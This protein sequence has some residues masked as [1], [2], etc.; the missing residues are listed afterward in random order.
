MPRRARGGIR[1]RHTPCGLHST[2]PLRCVPRSVT[3]L[4]ERLKVLRRVVRPVLVRMVHMQLHGRTA[5]LA[6]RS[7][8]LPSAH[9]RARPR[10]STLA[11]RVGAGKRAE[12]ALREGST[13]LHP[14]SL[15][16][17]PLKGRATSLADLVR[18]RQNVGPPSH[19]LLPR[20]LQRLRG[21]LVPRNRQT[22]QPSAVRGAQ[23][24]ATFHPGR[25]A[26]QHL[27]RGR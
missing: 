21:A 15:Q 4:A 1:G 20:T 13:V 3:A 22:H 16:A 6:A 18:R 23:L 5:V 8:K 2:R 9:M 27:A 7:E 14:A 25:R 11:L 17:R 19:S 10:T 12:A 24:A 26:S